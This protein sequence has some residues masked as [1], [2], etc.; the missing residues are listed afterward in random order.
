M[1]F[2]EGKVFIIAEAGVNHNGDPDLALRLVD[3]ATEAGADAVKFQTFKAKNL[4]SARAPKASY[5]LQTTDRM[6]SQFEMIRKLELDEAAHESILA[7]CARNGIRFLS[8]PFDPE[9]LDL[10]M[11]L[12]MEAIKLPSGEATNLPF[13]RLVGAQGKEVILST[14][15]CSLGE[16]EAA[17]AALAASGTPRERVVVL[18]AN[19]EYPTPYADVN[20]KA[21]VTMGCALGVRYG[22]SDHTPGIE[23]PIASVALGASVI[24]KHFTLDRGMDGPDHKASLEPGELKAMVA[25]IRNV[26]AAMGNGVKTP[27][28]S[29][30][31]NIKIARKSLHARTAIRKGEPFTADNLTAK[32]PGSGISPMRWDEYLGQPAPRDYAPDEML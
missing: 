19:T 21:M 10:L 30:A 28:A 12:G 2:P 4:L 9:S 17:L 13:L 8:T 1:G 29:E 24:E 31:K 27:S 5:Q 18:H 6:E 3:V 25:A 14:G 11:R 26:T 7:R 15:M 32:R 23:I 16:V 22:Y 20:L